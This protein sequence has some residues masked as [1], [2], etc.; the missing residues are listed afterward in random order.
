[1]HD[2]QRQAGTVIDVTPEMIEAGAEA[3]WEFSPDFTAV[4][5]IFAEIFSRMAAKIGTQP[6]LRQS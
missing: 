1:M 6:L 3:Y 5:E 4:S 2:S